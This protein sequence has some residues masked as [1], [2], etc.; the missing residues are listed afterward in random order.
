MKLFIVLLCLLLCITFAETIPKT[1]SDT[2]RKLEEI[3]QKL[4]K[5]NQIVQ[6][7]PTVQHK[8]P[9]SPSQLKASGSSSY[10]IV[11]T[12][13][14]VFDLKTEHHEIEKTLVKPIET[15]IEPE[16]KHVEKHIETPIEHK[17]EKSVEP[18]VKSSKKPVEKEVKVEVKISQ[19]KMKSLNPTKEQTVKLGE[20]KKFPHSLWKKWYDSG[21]KDTLIDSILGAPIITSKSGYLYAYWPEWSYFY[22]TIAT[23]GV[24]EATPKSLKKKGF[25]L[26]MK[27]DA[28]NHDFR[29][30]LDPKIRDAKESNVKMFTD[31]EWTIIKGLLDGITVDL[32][33][34]N[35]I[36]IF[37]DNGTTSVYFNDVLKTSTTSF[38]EVQ[39]D[40]FQRAMEQYR[41]IT[42]R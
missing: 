13:P 8:M 6:P 30:K 27:R 11:E 25:S 36:V 32:A 24:Y 41:A 17:V 38:S 23:Y 39:F 4:A 28:S 33:N 5:N 19:T 37:F 14:V 12:K 3:R 31:T 7:K 2:S 15:S 34:G 20:P 40:K 16:V 26:K 1:M 29:E 10:S 35:I 21:T 42:G 18:E 22:W 9:L